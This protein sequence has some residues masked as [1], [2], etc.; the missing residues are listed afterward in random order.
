M[1]YMPETVTITTVTVFVL[2]SPGAEGPADSGAAVEA[3]TGAAAPGDPLHVDRN[4]EF[5]LQVF[6]ASLNV[7]G[8]IDCFF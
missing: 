5:S 7:L 8:C 6:F 1:L 4:L 3:V 2:N